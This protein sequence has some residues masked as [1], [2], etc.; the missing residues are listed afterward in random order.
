MTPL[1]PTNNDTTPE[2]FPV[3]NLTEYSGLSI[4]EAFNKLLELNYFQDIIAL[5][6]VSLIRAKLSTVET[7]IDQAIRGELG[8]ANLTQEPQKSLKLPNALSYPYSNKNNSE[9]WIKKNKASKLTALYSCV[10][11]LSFWLHPRA[12]DIYSSHMLSLSPLKSILLPYINK[13]NCNREQEREDHQ[14]KKHNSRVSM[15]SKDEEWSKLKSFQNAA[16]LTGIVF[17]QTNTQLLLLTVPSLLTEKTIYI[18]GGGEKK[19]VVW[20]KA[21]LKPIEEK[22]GAKIKPHKVR[23]RNTSNKRPLNDDN[24][25][26]NAT[27]IRPNKRSKSTQSQNKFAQNIPNDDTSSNV[28]S[29]DKSGLLS[30]HDTEYNHSPSCVDDFYDYYGLDFEAD[31]DENGF[32]SNLTSAREAGEKSE[33]R[34]GVYTPVHED[35]S[36][37]PTNEFP[38]DAELGKEY[39]E[40]DIPSLELNAESKNESDDPQFIEKE[41]NNTVATIK[42]ILTENKA[43]FFNAQD[44]SASCD[45]EFLTCNEEFL[46]DEKEFLDSCKNM[47]S[48]Y[49]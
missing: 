16:I 12:K 32:L 27:R 42:N 10:Y 14:K 43:T 7:R 9:Q 11:I 46:T 1:M 24:L 45:E 23:S 33:H 26:S 5:E 39:I 3:G 21:I 34:I 41:A 30:T 29:S 49:T 15:P 25:T 20:R 8:W 38:T 17:T 13:V 19:E 22:F 2:S 35:S 48:S 36:N 47:T 28:N 44:N 6:E 18:S 4:E 31:V 40:N 37:E